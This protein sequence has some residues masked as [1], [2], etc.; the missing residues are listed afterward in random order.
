MNSN[1]EAFWKELIADC[2]EFENSLS[3]DYRKKTG[4]YFTGFEMAH[5]MVVDLIGAFRKKY[6]KELLCDKIFLEPCGGA[7][8]F[9]YCYLKEISELGFSANEI[10]QIIENIY[11]CDSNKKAADFY[12]TNIEKFCKVFFSITLTEDYFSSHIGNALLFD[13]SD[14]NPKYISLQDVFPNVKKADIV[15]TN[16]PYK[17]FKAETKHYESEKSYQRDIEIYAKVKKLSSE[18]LKYSTDGILNFYK[19]FVEEILTRYIDENSFV[20]LLIPSSILSDKS[21]V[22]LRKYILKNYKVNSIKIIPEGVDVVDAQQ[23]L[24]A[25]LINK[26]TKTNKIQVYKDFY[27]FP[28]VLSELQLN[29]IKAF[30]ADW[31]ILPLSNEEAD[32][33]KTLNSFPKVKDLPYIKNLRGELDVT[34]YKNQIVLENTGFKL[35]RGRNIDFYKTHT[36]EIE[37]FVS[38]DFIESCAKSDFIR[39]RRIICQQI[40]NKNKSRRVS[41]APIQE[42]IVLANSCNFIALEK[43]APVT[44]NFLMGVFN[45]SIINWYFKLSSTNNHINNY[46]IDEFPIPVNSPHKQEIDSLVSEYLSTQNENLLDEIETLVNKSFFTTEK[47]IGSNVKL[48]EAIKSGLER[49]QYL[50]DGGKALNHTTF[51]LSELDIETI[52]DVPQGGNWKNIPSE[53]IKKS[54]RLEK[55]AKNGGRTTLYGRIDYSKPAYTIT[56]YFNRPG[57]GTYVHPH[58]NRVISVRE[59]ARI[60]SFPDDYYFYGNKTQLLNQVGNA[61]PPLLA[62]QI[63]RKIIEKTNCTQTIDLFC[64]AGGMTCGFKIAGMKSLL[65]TDIEM[66]ACATLAIN[67]REIP[68]LCGDITKEKTK[69]QIIEAA[70][71]GN[72]EIICGGPPCQG[73]SMAGFRSPDDPRNQLFRDFVDIVKSVS[74]KIVVFENVEGLLSY[75]N[76]KT[77]KEILQLF[78]ELGYNCQGKLLNTS[79]Y[80]VPQRRKRVIIICTRK[81]LEL[82]PSELYPVPIT[83]AEKSKTTAFEAIG[84]LE[85][86]PCGE[87][88][89]YTAT[90][91]SDFA[92]MLQGKIST[93]E[94][95]LV[96]KSKE[97][98]PEQME[99][100][101]S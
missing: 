90:E 69:S 26:A 46:E 5:S 55:I 94:F 72:A 35:V 19:L 57:N 41:F 20:N 49:K 42:N 21:C 9:I 97:D 85:N 51:K 78:S 76:G 59:A 98:K 43:D 50:L 3:A 71:K 13:I 56:T 10:K 99:L 22:D 25:I 100:F 33:L 64:G 88:V 74:P 38:P 32:K 6:G 66:S 87:E 30:S 12:K 93:D 45:S 52:K 68:V 8:N 77:Y 23:S 63:A 75:E 86:I 11:Y 89:F 67:N 16:P 73:F 17:N 62:Y 28:K 70:K 4:S 37:E 95:L 40:V 58:F 2:K 101:A 65:A 54:K 92:K 24:C 61:V 96:Y 1:Q 80:A 29:D 83:F 79:D 60:Q 18:V 48:E 14:E 7:G 36:E 31:N 91:Q 39:S 44:L 27:H 53:V 81:D 84:D 82:L 15:I 47:S 34:L